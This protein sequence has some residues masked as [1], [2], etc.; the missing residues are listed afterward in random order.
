MTLPSVRRGI[1][2][3]KTRAHAPDRQNFQLWLFAGMQGAGMGTVQM[4][5]SAGSKTGLFRGA[6][7]VATNRR[8]VIRSAAPHRCGT[9]ATGVGMNIM[10]EKGSFQM[11]KIRAAVVITTEV[12]LPPVVKDVQETTF[13][14]KIAPASVSEGNAMIRTDLERDE[15]PW[16]LVRKSVVD[17][18]TVL[19]LTGMTQSATYVGAMALARIRIGDAS[20]AICATICDA[21]IA[22]VVA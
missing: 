2:V 3:L 1:G 8:R 14:A 5:L 4:D 10:A 9:V 18:A 13:V 16:T 11:K 21:S 7:G 22:A 15:I 20:G 6:A 19:P 12:A 17:G